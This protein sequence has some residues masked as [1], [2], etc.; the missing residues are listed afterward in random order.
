MN[1]RNDMK[2]EEKSKNIQCKLKLIG[3]FE[4]H[5]DFASIIFVDGND[6]VLLDAL[7]LRK[8]TH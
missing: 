2:I 3:C 5:L 4:L 8:I 7:L 6:V 1:E